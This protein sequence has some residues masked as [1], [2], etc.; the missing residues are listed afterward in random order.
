MNAFTC[1]FKLSEKNDFSST[2]EEEEEEENEE[3]VKRNPKPIK[4]RLEELKKEEEVF[5]LK[6][7]PKKV[8]SPNGKSHKKNQQHQGPKFMSS[9]LASTKCR[10]TNSNINL[11]DGP[12]RRRSNAGKK[13]DTSATGR[14]EVDYEA[15]EEERQKEVLVSKLCVMRVLCAKVMTR[16]GGIFSIKT[17]F[18]VVASI[19]I[20]RVGGGFQCFP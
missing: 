11:T 12:L 16:N 3:D 1:L 14:I 4:G 7:S 10:T 15:I 2:E 13:S 9:K 18:N 17:F 19:I 5:V 20:K 8:E 6:P